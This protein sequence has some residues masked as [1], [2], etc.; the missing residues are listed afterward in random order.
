MEPSQLVVSV[1][2][3]AIL[4]DSYATPALNG[5]RTAAPVRC[6]FLHVLASQPAPLIAA[7]H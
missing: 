4:S 2:P 1:N 7:S 3:A 5:E 6:A